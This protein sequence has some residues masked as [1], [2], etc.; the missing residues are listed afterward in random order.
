MRTEMRCSCCRCR[1]FLATP[2]T[3]RE[4]QGRAYT[5]QR[6]CFFFLFTTLSGH[7]GWIRRV[8]LQIIP[9]PRFGFE[10]TPQVADEGRSSRI[11]SEIGSDRF[12]E[13]DKFGL[14]LVCR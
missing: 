11:R 12:Q 14:A 8:S 5:H 1:S 4:L 13:F 2:E 10:L 3:R 9:F 7:F 6:T